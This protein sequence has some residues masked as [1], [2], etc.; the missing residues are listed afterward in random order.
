MKKAQ[1]VKVL[2]FSLCIFLFPKSPLTKTQYKL[3]DAIVR[4]DPQA[5]EAAI[6]EGAP[7]NSDLLGLPFLYTACLMGKF[8]AARVLV[9][10]GADVNAA[11]PFLGFTPLHWAAAANEADFVEFLI[12]HGAKVNAATRREYKTTEK[13]GFPK[14]ITP[15]DMAVAAK[16]EKAA[17]VLRKHGAR[18]NVL[19]LYLNTDFMKK[20]R[21]W[22]VARLKALLVLYEADE[23]NLEE[24]ERLIKEGLDP[25]ALFT[26]PFGVTVTLLDVAAVKDDIEIAKLAFKYGAKVN[27]PHMCNLSPLHWAALMGS[28]KVAKYLLE[29]GEDPNHALTCS[30]PMTSMLTSGKKAAIILKYGATPLGIATSLNEQRMIELLKSYGAKQGKNLKK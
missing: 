12:S 6:K 13:R 17:E 1:A 20:M 22:K 16:A 3:L 23:E 19:D 11:G 14:G 10:R 21:A 29:K 2:L 24:I 27:L 15:L 4:D 9:E 5:V 26:S 30:L 8:K 28:Y 7:A 25:N 18:R